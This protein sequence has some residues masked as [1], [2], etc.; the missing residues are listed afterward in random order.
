[1]ALDPA[2]ERSFYLTHQRTDEWRVVHVQYQAQSNQW[3]AAPMGIQ[4]PASTL[5]Y[6]SYNP[7]VD[8]VAPIAVDPLRT[9]NVLVG[10]E[11]GIFQGSVGLATTWAP[12]QSVP[13]IWTTALL[14]ASGLHNDPQGTSTSGHLG[15]GCLAAR[16][17]QLV[18]V[19][20]PKK[21]RSRVS[22]SGN[23]EGRSLGCHFARLF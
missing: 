16:L 2:D 8:Y 1:M 22:R 15:K 5:D 19:T 23:H 6:N 17:P 11:A 7:S 12:I 3:T 4:F 18:Y 10:T 13:N 20:A 14:T 21:G 9:S